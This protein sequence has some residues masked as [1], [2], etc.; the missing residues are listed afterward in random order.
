[1]CVLF[2]ETRLVTVA[3]LNKTVVVAIGP[4]HE[5]PVSKESF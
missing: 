4:L 3:C 5:H 2:R 1:M